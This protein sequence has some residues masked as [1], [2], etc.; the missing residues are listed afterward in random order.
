ME[1]P[2]SLHPFHPSSNHNTMTSWAVCKQHLLTAAWRQTNPSQSTLPGP[3]LT[4]WAESS[5]LEFPLVAAQADSKRNP[6]ILYLQKT[7]LPRECS[8]LS[9]PISV[10]R[11]TPPCLPCTYFLLHSCWVQE[12]LHWSSPSGLE[13]WNSLPLQA[14][15]G[16]IT[17][18]KYWGLATKVP[19]RPY[20]SKSNML[21]F[22]HTY[23]W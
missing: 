23:K 16:Y 2:S 3:V 13:R 20:L 1:P 15:S 5:L 9:S 8:D 17:A 10:F 14:K 19:G 11:L 4:W 22:Q 7:F 18:T 21:S 6:V 12:A